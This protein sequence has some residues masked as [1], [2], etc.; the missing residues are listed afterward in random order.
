MPKLTAAILEDDP[1][2]LKDLKEKVEATGLLTVVAW[3]TSPAE[4]LHHP[5]LAEAEVL[6]LDIDLGSNSVSG[7]D[8][9]RQLQRPVMFVTGH[10]RDYIQQIEELD[11][12]IPDHPVDHLTKPITQAKLTA[13]LGKF[14]AQVSRAAQVPPKPVIVSLTFRGG[15]QVRKELASIVFLE[16]EP[17]GNGKGSNKVIYFTDGPLQT[18]IDFSFKQLQQWGGDPNA[19]MP[20]SKSCYVNCQHV[21]SYDG[22]S[23]MLALE[24]R[25]D[26]NVSV[27]LTRS[28]SE[29]YR[30]GIEHCLHEA[31]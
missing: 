6:F 4:L 26:N 31:R 8:V 7:I 1:L 20:I 25:N 14:V 28:V 22:R 23:H 27:K 10:T 3:A 30:K 13:V 19:L 2:L 9:A 16:T 21:T 5:R 12:L 24:C 17:G 11:A 15:K 29:D 18:L